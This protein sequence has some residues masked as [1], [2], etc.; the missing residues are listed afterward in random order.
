MR[1]RTFNQAK[2]RIAEMLPNEQQTLTYESTVSLV[3]G[4]SLVP[5][6]KKTF[7]SPEDVLASLELYVSDVGIDL[8]LSLSDMV[9]VALMYYSF[10][11]EEITSKDEAIEYISNLLPCSDELDLD[12]Y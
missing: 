7:D 5:Y 3:G 10:K 8:A 2:A 6:E 12:L 1:R 4:M 9:V 11:V